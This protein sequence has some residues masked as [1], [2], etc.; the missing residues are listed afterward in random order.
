MSPAGGVKYGWQ[1]ILRSK[2][3]FGPYEEYVGMAQ[4]KSKVNGPHQ[5]AWVDTPKGEHW[6]LHFQDKHAY[7]RV[8]HLQPARWVDDWLV[9]GDDK[10]ND[11]C[12][13]PV[14][15]WKKPD[16]KSSGVFQPN[17]DDEFSSTKLGLQWPFVGPY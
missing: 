8:V 13:D 5:G 12:G 4:G 1:V 11:G 15:V 7:G 10:D 2:D 3:P 9:I 14:S 6:F 17:E 16:L